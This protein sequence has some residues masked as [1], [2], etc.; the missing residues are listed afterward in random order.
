MPKAFLNLTDQ[1]QKVWILTFV[2][3][4]SGSLA[5]FYLQQQDEEHEDKQHK[6]NRLRKESLQAVWVGRTDHSTRRSGCRRLQLN[7]K[8]EK[9]EI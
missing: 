5:A 1:I 8:K 9:E 7:T 4:V 6:E 3:S 2:F